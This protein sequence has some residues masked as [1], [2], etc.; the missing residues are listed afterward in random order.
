MHKIISIS[1]SESDFAYLK[2]D[3]Y[4][5]PSLVFRMALRN[6]RENRKSDID[7]IK[8]LRNKCEVLQKKIF[9]L[10]DQ[11]VNYKEE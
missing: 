7:K 8:M 9:D 4:L 5:K 10:Q 3:D 11:V 6:I 2:E 1:V